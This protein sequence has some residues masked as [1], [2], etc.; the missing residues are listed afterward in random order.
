MLQRNNIQYFEKWEIFF[1]F[2]YLWAG[3]V[4]VYMEYYNITKF[5]Q[6]LMIIFYK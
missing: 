2:A 1:S 3:E 5:Y 4:V 6:I